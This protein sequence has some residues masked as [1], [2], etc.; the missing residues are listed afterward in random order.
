GAR[1]SCGI[2]SCACLNLPL[3]IQYKPENMYLSI[4]PGPCGPKLTEL[5]HYIRPVVNDFVILWECG[6]HF[7][8]TATHASG[9]N[10]CSAI[11]LVVCDLPGTRKVSQAASI[12]SHFYCTVCNCYHLTT[13]GR[14]NFDTADWTPKD[15]TATELCRHA[16]EWKNA[17]TVKD[18]EK[19]FKLNGI[20]WSELWWLPYRNPPPQLVVNSMHCLLEGLAQFHFREVL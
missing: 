7:S 15:A 13:L 2:I 18:Q 6:V 9:R 20:Q 8:K 3:D 19:A 1:T 4:I 16:E 11:G 17:P 14:I 5:N 10:T 12:S